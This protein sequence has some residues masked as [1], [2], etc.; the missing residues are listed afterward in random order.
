[1]EDKKARLR[2]AA[3]KAKKHLVKSKINLRLNTGTLVQ[4]I[5]YSEEKCEELRA[6]NE[7]QKQKEAKLL[8]KLHGL[9]DDVAVPF[10]H[11]LL[12]KYSLQIEE[13]LGQN[14]ATRGTN[15][16]RTLGITT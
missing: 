7:G 4:S 15:E 13:I 5:Q 6:A 9:L 16:K 3:G 12:S 2:R 11:S 1:M 8:D 14:R 10:T